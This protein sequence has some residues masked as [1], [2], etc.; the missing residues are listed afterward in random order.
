MNTERRLPVLSLVAMNDAGEVAEFISRAGEDARFELSYTM[1]AEFVDEIEPLVA[2]KV[3]SIHACCPATENFPNFASSDL[4][5]VAD[6]FR[7]MESTMETALRF[8]ASIV[9]LH[10]GYA[11]D[12]AMPSEYAL[13][14]ILLA[15]KEFTDDVRFAD[16]SICGPEYNTT[17]RYLRFAERTKE[18]LALLAA[19]Y[20]KKGVRLAVENLNP[21][22]GYLFHTPDEMVSLAAVHPNLGLCLDVGHLYI[23]SFV[24]GFDYLDGIRK[25]AAT[26]KVITCHLH[27]NTSGPGRFRDDHQSVDK[28]GFPLAGA[29]EILSGTGTQLVLELLEEPLRNYELLRGM[30]DVR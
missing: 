20:E 1:S 11:T 8:G 10:S 15:R 25:I 21:R 26:G 13:R 5:V 4:L 27:S 12:E 23:S 29:L 22:V 30:L 3:T 16:G 18:N 24:Y 2:G 28:N 7:D 14:K 19:I 17:A 9:V 6:S